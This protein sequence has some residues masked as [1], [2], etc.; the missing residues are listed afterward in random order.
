MDFDNYN[1]NMDRSN[2]NM[3][4]CYICGED[5]TFKGFNIK[6]KAVCPDCK[7]KKEDKKNEIKQ[8]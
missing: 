4:K 3:I 2:V 6:R 5:Y 1:G 7:K 8:K